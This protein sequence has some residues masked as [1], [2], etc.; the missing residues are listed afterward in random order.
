[1]TSTGRAGAAE[2]WFPAQKS[3]SYA[4][5]LNIHDS[6]QVSPYQAL[7]DLQQ[8]LH[9]H[10]D[11]LVAQQSADGLEVRGSHKVP[12]GAVDVAVGNVEGLGTEVDTA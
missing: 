9:D 7:D 3:Q 4:Q 12:V 11:A 5:L 6:T 10:G 2:V 1:M 8:F